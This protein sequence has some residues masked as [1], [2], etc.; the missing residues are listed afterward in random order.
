MKI[1]VIADDLTGANASGVKL[2]KQGFQ[3]TTVVHSANVPTNGYHDVVIMDTDSRYMTKELARQRV[4]RAMTQLSNWGATVFTKRID[5]TIRGNIGEEIDE[6]LEHLDEQT[7]SVIV[8]SFP[9]SGR[10]TTGGYL[11]LDGVP[12]QETYVSK[13]PIA[14]ITKSYVPDLIAKQSVHK[15]GYV[16]LS[17]VMEGQSEILNAL[18]AQIEQGKRLIVVDAVTNEQIEDIAEALSQ[19]GRNIVCADPGPLTASYARALSKDHVKKANILVSVG[20]ATSLTG[21]QLDFLIEKTGATPIYVDPEPLA[22]YTDTWEKEVER[23]T[24]QAIEQAPA[25]HVLIVTTHK[26]GQKLVDL[27]AKADKEGTSRDALAKR[28]TDGL[29]TISRKLLTNETLTFAGCFTSGGDVTASV[30]A[31]GR[32][33]GISL[34]DEVMPLAAYGTFDGGY[35]DGLPIVTKGG[36]IGDKKAIY[37]CVKFV[38]TKAT[39]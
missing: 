5:S 6:I 12:L 24:E 33:N 4:A 3:A 2:V 27:Q 14:P 13:D 25:N 1:G 15:V 30:C 16:G 17:A 36:L 32:A 11:L 26:P 35:F 29:A 34:K 8:P 28:I 39:I 10:V 18:Q 20:S 31:L 7:I 19:S 23:A 9:D 37:E 21:S 38:Q 22:S